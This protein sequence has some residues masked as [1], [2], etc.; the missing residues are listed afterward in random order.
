MY[1]DWGANNTHKE[2]FQQYQL[3]SHIQAQNRQVGHT[4]MEG[5]HEVFMSVGVCLHQQQDRDKTKQNG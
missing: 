3:Y 5:I 2:T 1:L 4:A